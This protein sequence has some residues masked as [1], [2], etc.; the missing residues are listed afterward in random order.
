MFVVS[1]P[2]DADALD[3]YLQLLFEEETFIVTNL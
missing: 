3:S 2:T 1:S